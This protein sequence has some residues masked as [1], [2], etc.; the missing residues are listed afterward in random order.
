MQLRDEINQDTTATKFNRSSALPDFAIEGSGKYSFA[1]TNLQLYAQ[2]LREG[3]SN[4]DLALVFKTYELV[5]RLFTCLYRPSRNCFITHLVQTASILASLRVSVSLVTAGLLHAAYFRGDFGDGREGISESKREQI[6]TVV[7]QEGEEYIARYATLPWTRKQ[8]SSMHRDVATLGVIDRGVA[9]LHLANLLE[10]H[11]DLGILYC[12][13]AEK[14]LQRIQEIGTLVIELAGKL[15]FPALG[16]ELERVFNENLEGE[17]PLELRSHSASNNAFLIIPLSCR[18]RL[19]IQLRHKLLKAKERLIKPVNTSPRSL[20][21][22]STKSPK[23][24]IGFQHRPRRMAN[25]VVESYAQTN[26][27]LYNQLL[28]E[29]YSKED[30]VC[31][32]KV[33]ELASHL[34]TGRY[35]IHGKTHIAHVVRAASIL[36]SL[37]V[38]ATVVAA[39]LIH[40]VYKNGDFGTEDKGITKAKRRYVTRAVGQEVEQYVADFALLKW[41]PKTFPSIRD[42]LSA[43]STI[44]QKVVLLRL[45]D[46]LEHNLDSGVLYYHPRQRDRYFSHHIN[47]IMIQM[48]EQ[49][50]YSILAQELQQAYKT[51]SENVPP[52]RLPTQGT[53]SKAYAF[54]PRSCCKRIS[55]RLFQRLTQRSSHGSKKVRSFFSSLKMVA[56]TRPRL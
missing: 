8:I 48:A 51:N 42:G 24:S 7:G 4:E 33:Y 36:G 56:Q 15:E 37:H 32:L 20:P 3:Y 39:G 2:L 10:D 34:F 38:P 55:I 54:Y 46:L 29:G 30:L 6:R 16:V 35:L 26:I 22:E 21:T 28:S 11:L 45:A 52:F 17:I 31:V 18:R 5:R 40:N 49:L 47:P 19:W 13:N 12:P 41:S 44:E 14:R 23:G 25:N 27:Q 53:P 9:L 50:R 43:S 1:Q